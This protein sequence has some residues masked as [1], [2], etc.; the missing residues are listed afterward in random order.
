MVIFNCLASI[1]C[2]LMNKWSLIFTQA[3]VLIAYMPIAILH[4]LVSG[5]EFSFVCA[6]SKGSDGCMSDLSLCSWSPIGST[7]PRNLV[8]N[9]SGYRCGLTTDPG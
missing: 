6:I 8:G 9:M 7:R 5:E 4:R 3:M 1:H 2:H